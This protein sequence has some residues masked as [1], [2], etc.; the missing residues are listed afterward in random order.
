M[1]A[2]LYLSVGLSVQA[3]F[4]FWRWMRAPLWAIGLGLLGLT[5][6]AQAAITV[7]RTS[8]PI[9]FSNHSAG[10]KCSY[11]SFQ[12][13]SNVAEADV[14]ADITALGSLIKLADMED[15]KAHIGSMTTGLPAKLLSFYLC[16]TATATSNIVQNYT[17]KTYD[18]DPALPGAVTLSNN[19]FSYAPTAGN[20]SSSALSIDNATNPTSSN[21]VNVV[22]Y[23]PSAPTL[24]GLLTIST[25]GETGTIG[26]AGVLSFTPSYNPAWPVQAYELISTV[27]NIYSGATCTG[28]PAVVVRDVL[29]YKNTALGGNRCYTTD[30]VYKAI[31]VTASSFAISPNAWIS[32]GNNINYNSSAPVPPLLAPAT[33]LVRLA[34]TVNLTTLPSTG[35]A[36]TYT[37]AITNAGSVAVDLDK[38]VDIF[39]ASPAAVTYVGGSSV[40]NGV[41]ISDPS[42]TGSTVSWNRFFRIPA[43]ST[44]NLTYRAVVPGTAGSYVNQAVAY[45]GTAQ[46]DSTLSLN[47]NLPATARVIVGLADMAVSINAPASATVGSIVTA[48]VSFANIGPVGT[49]AAINPTVTLQLSSGLTGV[50]V[51]GGLLGIGLYDSASGIVTFPIAQTTLALNSTLSAVI[52]Y[53]Q[54]NTAVSINATTTAANDGNS[55]NNTLSFS[56]ASVAVATANLSLAKTN[57]PSLNVGVAADYLLSIS[58]AS[59]AASSGLSV[60]VNDKLPPNFVFNSAAPGIGATGTN[61]V[62]TGALATGLYL[63]CTV[64][65]ASG[66]AAGGVA[67]F[68]VN[69]TPQAAAGGVSSSNMAAVSPAGGV[70]GDPSLCS[71]TGTPAGCAVAAAITPATSDM[72][73]SI[74]APLYAPAGTTVEGTVNF[75]NIGASAAVNPTVS[76][77]LSPGLTG[78][79]VNGGLL[80]IGVY[81]SASGLVT[82]PN[83]QTTLAVN[84]TLS[85]VISYTQPSTNVTI[86]ATTTAAND[87]NT[88]NNSLPPY[89]VSTGSVPQ[90][91]LLTHQKTVQ[92]ISDPINSTTNPKNIPGAV[93][94]YTLTINNTGPGIVDANTLAIVDVVPTNSELFTGNLSANAPYVF[95]NGALASG[96]TCPFITLNNFTDCVDFSANGG[97]TWDYGPNGGYDP[98]VT[99]IRFRLSGTMNGDAAVGAPYPGFAIQFRVRVK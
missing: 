68:T 55:A 54:P 29:Y 7:T 35:G 84:A 32:A 50:S 87:T 19:I 61:C 90:L 67:S 22:S 15:G 79:V 33:N 2:L 93:S 98:A 60:V 49:G 85:A 25:Q 86:S 62:A 16:E 73:V 24:G 28:V 42:I 43:N 14:W 59:G 69:V 41:G 78:V 89:T 27:I 1:R 26:A 9:F 20:G 77:Q 6:T 17:I 99:H 58:N 11:A 37:V 81:D 46:I 95:T 74:N 5:G 76:L 91:P 39:P 57:P 47:D 75:V 52:T 71:T 65:T 8:T 97:T 51:N 70:P 13:T 82:F 34:K 44:V 63:V 18:R 83:A 30:Y 72:A 80:G 94:D 66:I 31:G 56:V 38:I 4:V 88:T 10:I 23:S 36:V 21:K 40:F 64:T 3:W 92:V 45:I 48:T 53:T 12:I 96:L